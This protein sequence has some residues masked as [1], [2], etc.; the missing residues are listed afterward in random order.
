MVWDY[1]TY[2]RASNPKTRLMCS[3]V[4]LQKLN[5]IRGFTLKRHMANVLRILTAMLANP[6]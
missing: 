1:S 3:S 6:R 5:L 2:F 4:L